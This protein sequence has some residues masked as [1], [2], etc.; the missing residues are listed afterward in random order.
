MVTI[1]LT[2]QQEAIANALV[3]TEYYKTVSEIGR[4][5]FDKFLTELPPARKLRI[6]MRLYEKG[7]ATVS[8]VA[9]IADIPLHEARQ[10]LRD[11]GLLREG[12]ETSADEMRAKAKAGAAKYRKS[13]GRRV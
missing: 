3:E 12:S 6:A 1:H 9:E 13:P 5:A 4:A 10:A 2:P 7:E 11:E 8:R